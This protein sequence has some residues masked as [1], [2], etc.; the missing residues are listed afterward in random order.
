MLQAQRDEHGFRVALSARSHAPVALPFGVALHRYLDVGAVSACVVHGLEACAYVDCA[1]GYL[2]ITGKY[3]DL[4]G[5]ARIHE[6]VDPAH[7]PAALKAIDVADQVG[8]VV[9]ASICSTDGA[10]LFMAILLRAGIHAGGMACDV[11]VPGGSVSF[12]RLY[13]QQTHDVSN[14]K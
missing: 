11:G 14:P 8:G 2:A 4:L 9:S 10:R 13:I 12:A 1:G 3:L 5:L 6:V 7:D